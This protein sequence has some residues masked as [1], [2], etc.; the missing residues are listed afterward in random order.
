MAVLPQQDGAQT[1]VGMVSERALHAAASL[2]LKAL[3]PQPAALAGGAE[4]LEGE[5]PRHGYATEFIG[6]GGGRIR[7]ELAVGNGS[8]SGV[9]RHL[10]RALVVASS[11]TGEVFYGMTDNLFDLEFRIDDFAFQF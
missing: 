2:M 9:A 5:V 3:L 11:R 4:L 7:I 10:Q 8:E 1:I 6:A